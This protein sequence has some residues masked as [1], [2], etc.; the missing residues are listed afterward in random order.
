M[1]PWWKK[2]IQG[3]IKQLRQ[4]ITRLERVTSGDTTRHETIDKLNKRCNIK[5]KGRWVVTEELKQR[6][7]AQTA[8]LKRHEERQ[9]QKA[10]F[11]RQ[12][13]NGLGNWEG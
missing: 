7:T 9:K 6:V 11:L 12:I 8:K 10:G 3:E 13:K 4:D 5:E 1:K 2:R